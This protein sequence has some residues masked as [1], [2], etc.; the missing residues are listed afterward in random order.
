MSLHFAE[1]LI[2]SP[3][4]VRQI[5]YSAHK[6]FRWM[7]THPEHRM[8]KVAQ[9]SPKSDNYRFCG[10]VTWRCFYNQGVIVCVLGDSVCCAD[11]YRYQLV[12]RFT[13]KLSNFCCG[14]QETR[15]LVL[16]FTTKLPSFWPGNHETHQL[17][18][19]FTTKLSTFWPN[20]R[21]YCVCSPQFNLLCFRHSVLT[22]GY[23]WLKNHHKY[24]C[25]SWLVIVGYSWL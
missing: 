4:V 25:H 23:S 9:A 7:L 6:S 16:R 10:I 17:V 11:G 20:P 19:G 8:P 12:L 5:S 13:T 2:I 3:T 22:A 24:S 1:V 14:N 15:Q 21:D 18:S